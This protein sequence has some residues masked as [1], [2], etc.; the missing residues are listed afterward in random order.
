MV[1]IPAQSNLNQAKIVIG[2]TRNSFEAIPQ[3]RAIKVTINVDVY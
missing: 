1:K 3:Y 2:K